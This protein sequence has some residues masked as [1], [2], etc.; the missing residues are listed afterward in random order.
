RGA[1]VAEESSGADL[2]DRTQRSSPTVPTKPGQH[3]EERQKITPRSFSRADTAPRALA[4]VGLRSDGKAIRRAH[5][6]RLVGQLEEHRIASA[7]DNGFADRA[8]GST[9]AEL[10]AIKIG[11]LIDP[12]EIGEERFPIEI[13]S[14]SLTDRIDVAHLDLTMIRKRHASAARQRGARAIAGAR[15]FVM[16]QR[17]VAR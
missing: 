8:V 1:V 6:V 15:E 9:C 17:G 14:M 4:F 2:L 5:D 10:D 16:L 12:T 3:C 7:E 13:R 11:A